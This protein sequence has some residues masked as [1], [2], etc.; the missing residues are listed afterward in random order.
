MVVSDYAVDFLAARIAELARSEKSVARRI[1]ELTV[2]PQSQQQRNILVKV[3][4][5]LDSH[6]ALMAGLNLIAD[7]G[8]NP[9]PYELRKGIEDLDLEN[10]ALQWHSI[11]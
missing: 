5:S 6:Q 9:I 2:Q 4:A 11:L 8:A 1:F 10:E 7:A 3:I